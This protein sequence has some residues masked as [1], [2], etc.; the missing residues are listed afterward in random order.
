MEENRRTTGKRKKSMMKTGQETARTI[1][2]THGLKEMRK[3]KM[4]ERS[5]NVNKEKN[6]RKD[7][8]KL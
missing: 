5:G 2:N 3:E 4:K 1:I 8:V 6:G 7:M